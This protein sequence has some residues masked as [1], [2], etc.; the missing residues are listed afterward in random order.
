MK[1]LNKNYCLFC[2]KYIKNTKVN[3]NKTHRVFYNYTGQRCFSCKINYFYEDNNQ[4]HL[5]RSDYIYL[6]SNKYVVEYYKQSTQIY[7]YFKESLNSSGLLH[8][9]EVNKIYELIKKEEAI[10]LINTHAVFK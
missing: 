8:T 4:H 1:E 6:N 3:L 2:N 7:K 5:I 10:N 9:V